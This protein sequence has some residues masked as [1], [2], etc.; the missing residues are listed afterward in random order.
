MVVAAEGFR[1]S[2]YFIPKEILE[3][4]GAEIKNV[5][6]KK[7]VARGAD[8]GEIKTDLLIQDVNLADFD[9]V[10]FIG[11]P[12]ALK[13]LDNEFSY[14]LA[15]AAIERGKILG[16]ICISPSILAKA[17]V[18]KDKRATVWTSALDKSP[19]KILTENGAIYKN[20]NVVVEGKIIT[21]DGPSSAKEFGE[22]ILSML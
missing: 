3:N 13:H 2:E 14:K 6:N 7:G 1:D 22:K 5:S 4:N 11:G 20:K 18:L 17:G 10:I 16:A 19:V 15:R 8:G 21:A 9:A 12:G